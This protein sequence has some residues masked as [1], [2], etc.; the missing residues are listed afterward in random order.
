VRAI[1]E[2]DVDF[3]HIRKRQDWVGLPVNAGDSRAIEPHLFN[4]SSADCL[5]DITFDL[6]PYSVRVDDLS[7]ILDCGEVLRGD[8]TGGADDLHRHHHADIGAV[9]FILDEGHSAPG[10]RVAA[11]FG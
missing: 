2:F 6:I 7:A 3:R 9:I 4:E 11:L 5:Y 10:G 1:D 8:D